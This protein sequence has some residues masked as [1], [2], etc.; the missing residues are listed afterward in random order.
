MRAKNYANVR[1]STNQRVN[2]NGPNTFNCVQKNHQIDN[3][4]YDE[5]EPDCIHH[6]I[7]TNY[8]CNNY[9]CNNYPYNNCSCN[10]CSCNN[11][12]ID[13]CGP[14]GP[15]GPC[16][17][18]GPSGPSGLSGPSGPSGS[19]G[20][21]GIAGTSSGK[22]LFLDSNSNTIANPSGKINGKLLEIPIIEDYKVISYTFND[23]KHNH[24][25]NRAVFL[26]SFTSEVNIL[27]SPVIPGEYWKLNVNANV[28]YDTNDVELYGVVY[29][30]KP[31]GTP[32]EIGNGS[33]NSVTIGVTTEVYSNII[34]VFITTIPDVKDYYNYKI[35]LDLYAIQ[36]KN[37]TKNTF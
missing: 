32:I 31:D 17:P 5:T 27:N 4:C 34:P 33:E 19:K 11:N 10:N 6:I 18:S 28:K 13:V 25:H 20:E 24:S 1:K 26:S 23:N 7:P 14:P 12:L 37:V 3:S 36:T 16:G 21:D 9:P 2:I 29:Y 8:P 35:R 30:I 15:H 22:V